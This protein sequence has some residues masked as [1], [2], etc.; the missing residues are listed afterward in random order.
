MVAIVFVSASSDVKAAVSD[1]LV[2]KMSEVLGTTTRSELG[3]EA[4]CNARLSAFGYSS[5]V[6]FH[7]GA[8]ARRAAIEAHDARKLLV[9]DAPATAARLPA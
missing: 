4:A 7:L 3:D 2:R 1:L 9:V 6:I 8:E 5:T